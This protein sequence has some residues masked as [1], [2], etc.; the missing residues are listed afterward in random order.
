MKF[1][2]SKEVKLLQP[3]NNL[4]IP[5]TLS[6]LKF[7]KLILFNFSHLK[8]IKLILFISLALKLL[9]SKSL[10]FV[11]FINKYIEFLLA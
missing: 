8:N 5:L 1:V 9:N 2:K 11:K 3:S 10:R 7:S 4:Y 6:V